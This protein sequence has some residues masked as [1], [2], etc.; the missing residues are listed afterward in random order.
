[1]TERKPPGLDFE[2][3]V[4]RQFREAEERGDFAALAGRGKPLPDES[5][6]YDELWWVKQKMAREGLSHL[7]AS[8]VLRKEAE[9]TLAAAAEAPSEE[10]ARRMVTGLNEKISA[11]L[12]A[13]LEGPP[14]G[15]V[16]YD[17]DAFAARWRA[18]HGG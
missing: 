17:V 1:M 6:R 3:W 14:L 12:R 11:A 8:L 2:S 16:P 13:P 9:D 18:T 7:P 10:R 15:L 4:D 5:P